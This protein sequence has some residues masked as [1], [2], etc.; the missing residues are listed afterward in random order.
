MSNPDNPDTVV[1][2]SRYERMVSMILPPFGPADKTVEASLDIAAATL[3][4]TM[5]L[6]LRKFY[7]HT[8][9]RPEINETM[10]RLI[11][12]EL[13]QGYLLFYEENQS[14]CYWGIALAD[15]DKDDPP[16]HRGIP[17]DE[18]EWD[19]FQETATLSGFLEMN[20]AWQISHG[21]VEDQGYATVDA[22]TADR[23]FDQAEGWEKL[24]DPGHSGVRAMWREGQ[25]LALIGSRD[26]VDLTGSGKTG[27]DL[28]AIATHFGFRWENYA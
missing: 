28:E 18:E 23:I 25:M 1:A 8:S 13:E 19:W 15:L 12:P 20:L 22:A 5:P 24:K 6:L 11:E 21:S 26:S 4:V 9:N 14:V 16:V 27:E 3:D 2:W 7:A 10:D 17:S